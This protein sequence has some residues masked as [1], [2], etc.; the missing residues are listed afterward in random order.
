MRRALAVQFPALPYLGNSA[1]KKD[2]RPDSTAARSVRQ[3]GGGS[4]AE[5]TNGHTTAKSDQETD[6]GY[7][8][9]AKYRVAD[10]VRKRPRSA[11]Q[12]PKK[13]YRGE[14]DQKTNRACAVVQR[15]KA[16]C[17][18]RSAAQYSVRI[19]SELEPAR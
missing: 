7:R 15:V 19:N 14:P 11:T 5:M 9:N 4:R 13:S 12:R 2:S 8:H 1:D 10:S 17:R 18:E 3:R 6:G 16:D